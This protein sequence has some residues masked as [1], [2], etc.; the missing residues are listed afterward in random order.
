MTDPRDNSSPPLRDLAGA[1]DRGRSNCPTG[2]T[3]ARPARANSASDVP[4]SPDLLD[5][6]SAIAVNHDFAEDDRV[7][8]RDRRSRG[9]SA[10]E[11]R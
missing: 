10:R 3:V 5:R 7:A 1:D 4:R 8:A 6:S 2:A 9:H 11:R